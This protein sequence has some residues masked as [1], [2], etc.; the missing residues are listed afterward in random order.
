MVLI[1]K[2]N[3][4]IKYLL[5]LF[6]VWSCSPTEVEETD[7]ICTDQQACNYNESAICEYPD[8]NFDCAGNYCNK[9]GF[10]EFN[11]ECY[12]L[13][14]LNIL[15]DIVNQNESLGCYGSSEEYADT[16]SN[17]IFEPAEQH[18]DNLNGVYDFGEE[19]DD[20]NLNGVYDEYCL[21]S[22][23]QTWN[24]LISEVVC[25]GA[26]HSWVFEEFTDG[27]GSWDEGEYYYDTNLNELY[28]E[29][30][31]FN[32]TNG[33]GK[34]DRNACIQFQTYEQCQAKSE[35]F[36]CHWIS[37][38]CYGESGC[39]AFESI[40]NCEDETDNLNC[41]WNWSSLDNGTKLGYQNWRNGRITYLDLSY[42][43]IHTIPQN[44]GML[45]NL[46]RLYLH[47]N[48]LTSLPL[49][50][51]ELYNLV[52]LYLEYNK[53]SSIPDNI[54]M[55]YSLERLSL[56]NNELTYIPDA[57]GDLYNLKDLY[58]S[59]NELSSIPESLYSLSELEYLFF[60]HNQLISIQENICE[61]EQCYINISSNY[62]CEEYH[63]Y[64]ADDCV[65][66]WFIQDQSNCCDVYEPFTDCNE[67]G[68]I[69]DNDEQWNVNLG[70]GVWDED[71]S[72]ID[73]NGNGL[74]DYVL[75]DWINC[76]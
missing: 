54:G 73:I 57:I 42:L 61:L 71:E 51:G 46:E 35:E 60:Q 13:S 38:M 31:S 4:S 14:D 59:Y 64:Y 19:F 7:N 52:G 70:N 33:N 25:E 37:K 53:L 11:G 32:D 48:E 21:D 34:W 16:N 44:I 2:S 26:G 58:L 75:E 50:I 12:H 27:N 10:Q 30:E 62:L 22:Y 36:D 72:F 8:E 67:S 74:Y 5:I 17:G 76:Y 28:D 3:L 45:D 23:T 20:V 39:S 40:D 65:D 56:Y 49:S 66:S 24:F 29:G 43:S 6:L 15:L 47:N 55:L 63:K 41:E 1:F 69:C 18:V 9:E 68:S